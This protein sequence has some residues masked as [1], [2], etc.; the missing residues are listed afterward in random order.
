MEKWICSC[1]AEN[2]GRFCETCG[3]ARPAPEAAVATQAS[4]PLD[5]ATTSSAKKAPSKKMIAV[6]VALVIA[7]LG[8][9]GYGKYIDARYDTKCDSYVAVLAE[10]NTTLDGVG[11]LSSDKDEEEHQQAI[12]ALNKNIDTLKE[13]KE[14]FVS[15]K[16]PSSAEPNREVLTSLL[17]K[18]IALAESVVAV[19][20]YDESVASSDKND[21]ME[22]LKALGA[23]T[24]TVDSNVVDLNSSIAEAD[25]K[26]ILFKGQSVDEL[27][28]TAEVS[29]NVQSYAL[30][31]VSFDVS[32]AGKKKPRSMPKR[33]WPLM[34]R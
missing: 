1:G 4:E 20:S 27:F 33:L 14:Y 23:L 32:S 8:Y 22:K 29:R 11:T 28:N 34:M 15:A 16:L 6:V 31:K 26:N 2:T 19:L 9:I 12:D 30:N 17:E 13:I 10:L 21:D 7:V 5:V 3:T 25:E 24:D 18:N